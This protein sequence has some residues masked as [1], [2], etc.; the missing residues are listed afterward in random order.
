MAQ[1]EHTDAS[2]ITDI[3]FNSF[4]LLYTRGLLSDMALMRLRLSRKS[5]KDF[6]PA[7]APTAGA[8]IDI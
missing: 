4:I 2:N 3:V 6:C 1:L 7:R 8:S 5:E